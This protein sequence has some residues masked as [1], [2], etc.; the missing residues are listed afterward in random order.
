M[1][2]WSDPKEGAMKNT[3]NTALKVVFS[4]VIVLFTFHAYGTPCYPWEEERNCPPGSAT[5]PNC[6]ALY[7]GTDGNGNCVQGSY[8]S[9]YNSIGKTT[10]LNI[11]WPVGPTFNNKDVTGDG[12]CYAVPGFAQGCYPNFLTPQHL[13]REWRQEIQNKNYNTTSGCQY[14]DSYNYSATPPGGIGC[15]CQPNPPQPPCT[16]N[17][18]PGCTWDSVNCIWSNCG[19]GSPVIIDLDNDGYAL[20]DAAH[21]VRFDLAGT[22]QPNQWSWTARNSDDAFLALDRNGDGQITNGKELFGNF[23][24]QPVSEEPNGFIAL[25]VF[26]G[27]N[28]RWID[29]NDAIYRRVLL[30]VDSNHDGVSQPSELHSLDWGGIDGIS[31]DYKLSRRSDQY[32]N[33]F[34]YRSLV[35]GRNLGRWAWD[36]FL[37]QG[38]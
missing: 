20:T 23:T 25:A 21:G 26:D 37:L 36:V 15:P 2:S 32:G 29:Q 31:L 9:A 18:P 5:N 1:E 8:P 27:N 28:D 6:A 24:D 10:Y 12:V 13:D 14:R 30:W 33:N 35:R 22:G 4:I 34:R 38:H 16:P 19:Q 17:C 7:G 11:W 3:S